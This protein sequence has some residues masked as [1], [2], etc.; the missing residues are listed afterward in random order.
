MFGHELANAGSQVSQHPASPQQQRDFHEKAV[1]LGIDLQ[2]V[3][4]RC[5]EAVN[6]ASHMSALAIRVLAPKGPHSLQH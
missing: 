1:D 6:A 2:G 5:A 3:E 4:F